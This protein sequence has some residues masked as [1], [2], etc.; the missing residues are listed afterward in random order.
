MDDTSTEDVYYS[1]GYN[2]GIVNQTNFLI[3]LI[4]DSDLPNKA[5]VLDLI[6]KKIKS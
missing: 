2:R 3:K 4:K 5:E 6:F 1:R